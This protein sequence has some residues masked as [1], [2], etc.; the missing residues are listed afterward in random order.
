MQIYLHFGMKENTESIVSR[1]ANE[2]YLK[3]NRNEEVTCF[4]TIGMQNY[5][6]RMK[7]NLKNAIQY[8]LR[9]LVLY[10]PSNHRL[11]SVTKSFYMLSSR[12]G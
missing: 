8:N 9:M 6:K 2:V 7:T 1:A 4:G 3:D 5:K 11:M 10:S 12:A